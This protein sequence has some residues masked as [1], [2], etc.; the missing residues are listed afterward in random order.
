M[1][2][3]SDPRFL[4]ATDNYLRGSLEAAAPNQ[5][6]SARRALGILARICPRSRPEWGPLSPGTGTLLGQEAGWPPGI[7]PSHGSEP[8]LRVASTSLTCWQY[9]G[10]KRPQL[11]RPGVP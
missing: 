7:C 1:G 3:Y 6:G 9:A 4:S 8:A 2:E 5:R 11:T 10:F